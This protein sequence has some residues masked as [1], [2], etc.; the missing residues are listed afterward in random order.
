MF[1]NKDSANE[2]LQYLNSRHNNIKFTIEF[3]HDNE[4]PFFDI[5]IKRGPWTPS[6]WYLPAEKDIHKSFRILNGTLSLLAN[7]KYYY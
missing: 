7:T 5:L 3:E 4:I 1:N 6:L 2:I